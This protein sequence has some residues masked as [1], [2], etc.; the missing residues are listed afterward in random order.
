MVQTLQQHQHQVHQ[1]LNAS[2]P[3]LLRSQLKLA[4][5]DVK[6]RESQLAAAR[7]DVTAQAKQVQQLTCDRA[8]AVRAAAA[9]ERALQEERRQREA[10]QGAQQ[11]AEREVARLQEEL[12]AANRLRQEAEGR[13]ATAEAAAEAAAAA[14]AAEAAAAATAPSSSTGAGSSG[15][16][17]SGSGE[18]AALRQQL[19]KEKKKGEL[20]LQSVKKESEVGVLWGDRECRTWFS[21]VADWSVAPQGAMAECLQAGARYHSPLCL[22]TPLSASQKQKQLR[23]QVAGVKV[24]LEAA[25]RG[26]SA[27]QQRFAE[28][29]SAAAAAAAG[30]R[31][32]QAELQ[33]G[34]AE[35]QQR[36]AELEGSAAASLAEHQQQQAALEQWIADLQTVATAA[37]EGQQQAAQQLAGARCRWWARLGCMAVYTLIT[38]LW[39][40]P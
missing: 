10:V 24:E 19:A 18:V 31:Q 23:Q 40:A 21:F 37:A 34:V 38:I 17:G 39:A 35:L 29:E 28:L 33:K 15:A 16:G 36:E 13:A 6:D 9:A 5:Q 2:E 1:A 20:L 32:Q 3:S 26:R 27:L 14:A 12:A 25:A 22:S 7:A 30:A 11:A 8:E 4:Q